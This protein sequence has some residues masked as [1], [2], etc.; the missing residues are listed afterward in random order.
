MNSSHQKTR[1]EIFTNPVAASL[2]W[3]RI[4]RMLC[5]LGCKVVEG[6]GSRV[7]FRYGQHVLIVHRPHPAKEAKPYQVRQVREFLELIGHKS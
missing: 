7:R 1:V 4:E 3:M 6:A 2:E 5:A